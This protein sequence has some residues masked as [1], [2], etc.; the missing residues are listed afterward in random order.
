MAKVFVPQLPTRY[1]PKTKIHI[2]TLDITQ[3]TAYGEIV[4][5]RNPLMTREDALHNIRSQARAEIAPD[6]CVMAIGDVVILACVIME[7]IKVNGCVNVL[8]WDR[9]RQSYTKE[10]IRE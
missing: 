4:I 9:A 1:D 2:P 5:M 3:A 10:E 8:R 6:D 7:A